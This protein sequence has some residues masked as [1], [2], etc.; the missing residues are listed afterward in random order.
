MAK[1]LDLSEF[2]GTP[3]LDLTEFQ[4]EPAQPASKLRRVADTGLALGRGIIGV[5]EFGVGLADIVTGGR[6]GKAVENA[7]VRFKDARQVLTDMQSDEQKAAD[8]Q[9]QQADGFFPT[10]GAMVKNPSTIV[11]AVA[12]SVPSMLA[13]GALSQGLVRRGVGGIT[14][15]A[16]G[17]GVVSAGQTAEQVRQE[18]KT[19]FLT[20][21]QAALSAGSGALTGVINKA[22]GTLAGKLGIADV[23]TAMATG[24]IGGTTE[25]GIARRVAEGALNEGVLQELPQSAQEQAAQNLALDRPIGEGV[26]QAAASGMLVGGLTGGGF[27]A[28]SGD[29]TPPPNQKG[30][31]PGVTPNGATGV[32]GPAET[33]AIPPST[34][35]AAPTVV[36]GQAAPAKGVPDVGS[37]RTERAGDHSK[38]EASIPQG[39]GL[40]K[41]PGELAGRAD[42]GGSIGFAQGSSPASNAG[43]A[44]TNAP[45]SKARAMGIDAAAGPLSAGAAIA[46]DTGADVITQTQEVEKQ[47]AE[48]DSK[49]KA[50]PGKDGKKHEP[51]APAPVM[52][53]PADPAAPITGP[54]TNA[55]HGGSNVAPTPTPVEPVGGPAATPTAPTAVDTRAAP[56]VGADQ[57]TP[58]AGAL[59][60]AIPE[61]VPSAPITPATQENQN[62]TQEASQTGAQ[63]ARVDNA[64][65]PADALDTGANAKGPQRAADQPAAPASTSAATEGKPAAPVEPLDLGAHTAATSPHNDL[66]EPT[67]AQKEAGNYKKAH[68]VV[69]GVD[70]SVENPQ[71]SVRRGTDADG[72]DWSNTM[73]WHYGYAKR[74]VGSDD[75]QQDVFVKP[76]MPLDYTGPVF[77][78]DQIDPKTGK[79]D[80]YKSMVGAQS[81]MEARKA[82]MGHYAKG[83]KGLKNVTALNWDQWREWLQAPKG[84]APARTDTD[85]QTG[86]IVRV[87]T[88]PLKGTVRTV[89]RAASDGVPGW[90]VSDAQT[91]EKTVVGVE[92]VRRTEPQASAG[93][94]GLSAAPTPAPEVDI[95]QPDQRT[96]EPSLGKTEVGNRPSTDGT[97][98]ETK[99]KV[100]STFMG[101]YGKGMNRGAASMEAIRLNKAN[102]TP[103]VVY[104]AEEHGDPAIENPYAVV[105][106]KLVDKPIGVGIMVQ[107]QENARNRFI[108]SAMEQFSMTRE[109]ASAALEHLRDKKLVKLDPI[110]GQFNLKD[111]RFWNKEVLSRAAIATSQNAPGTKS[112]AKPG[113][114]ARRAAY[115]KNPLMTFL[116]THGLYHEKGKPGSQKSEFSPD[117]FIPV[118]G[119]GMVFRRT[120]LKP[121]VMVARA[122]EDGY[123]PKDGT[124]SQLVDLIRRAIGGERI[125]PM[126]AEGVA[127]TEM[128]KQVQAIEDLRE[129]EDNEV[130]GPDPDIFAKSNVSTEDA[131]RD[132]GFTEQEIHDATTQGPR[133]PQEGRQG[134]GEPDETQAPAA[135][136]AAQAG[137]PASGP[138][139]T[140]EG[141]TA[142]TR[143]DVLTQQSQAANAPALDDKAQI[144]REAAAQTLTAQ[145]APEQRKDNTGDMFAV[146]KAQATID[147]RN[148]GG[149]KPTGPSLFDEP[150]EPEATPA[151]VAPA[152]AVSDKEYP[153][154]KVDKEDAHFGARVRITPELRGESAWEGTVQR[155]MNGGRLISVKRDDSDS[156]FRIAGNRIE[157]LPAAPSTQAAPTPAQKP[158]EPPVAPL[159]FRKTHNVQIQVYN[160]ETLAFEPGEADAHTAV[161]TLDADIAELESFKLCIGG[162]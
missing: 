25:K 45:P 126:Y 21:T 152:A 159:S 22:S 90:I 94:G 14:A 134:R 43:D 117:R 106:R 62:A 140:A 103:G 17:E 75:E 124:E 89:I 137:T 35:Q 20:P 109:A 67:P 119:Y 42:Q 37:V 73:Q 38:P 47:K 121:D 157:V 78:V 96:A 30:A 54:F 116:A 10:V 49:K 41:G 18:T 55:I 115:D 151:P 19:G 32:N 80:E 3:Q 97:A 39:D 5:P 88:G 9:V 143:A 50:K 155:V 86:D 16:A 8:A 148:A 4:Q 139:A 102:A 12:E 142:P 26:A 74:T 150:A 161:T 138:A 64:R 158:I 7:G 85:I 29:H 130:A 70:I 105:G 71:G 6:A 135:P 104:T 23:N 92:F 13:G 63:G 72:K 131:M 2:G 24:K 87:T 153:F 122:I 58:G 111:G 145:S 15:G 77:V 93:S 52:P 11:N 34:G 76:G 156:S 125:A 101:K 46:V 79:H 53:A 113:A 141:L 40:G 108:D 133:A 112:T 65:R 160:E 120:G 33:V 147:K 98:A 146:E 144:A 99:G 66:P 48:A 162:A 127:E 31:V 149:T 44:T 91:G 81:P 118:P 69:S 82:Y 27:G 107:R 60:A 1:D 61:P 129:L 123:L 57:G 56:G 154:G 68:L 136:S 51:E 83:W 28:L 36:G 128:E 114:G 110:T 95:A 100:V 132:M 84:T 59:P